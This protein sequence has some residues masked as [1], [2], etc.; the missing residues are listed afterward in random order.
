M[1]CCPVHHTPQAIDIDDDELARLV[2][3]IME[4]DDLNSDG[5]VDYYEFQKAQTRNQ[6]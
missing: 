4:D 5:Y 6:Q 3:Q 2:E 1:T